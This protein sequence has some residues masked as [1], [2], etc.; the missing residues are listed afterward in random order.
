MAIPL[1]P[2]SSLPWKAADGQSVSLGVEP[3]S[4]AHDQI[5][6][7]LW[8]LRSCFCGAPSLSRMSFVYA[9]GPC[10]RSLFRVRVPWNSRPYFTVS[11]LRLSFSS[12]PTT[13]RVTVEVFNPG[14][15]RVNS[16]TS[17]PHNHSARTTVG[18]PASNRSSSVARGLLLREPVCLRSLPRNGS[19][20]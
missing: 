10:R 1:L 17:C 11:D 6:I 8:Q 16:C 2:C 5:F 7:T 15:T 12:P 20:V 9:A 19:T 4:G 14:S 13:R 3:P 18:N